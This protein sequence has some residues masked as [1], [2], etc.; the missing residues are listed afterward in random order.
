MLDNVNMNLKKYIY[1]TTG[2]YLNRSLNIHV[3]RIFFLY[4]MILEKH[5]ILLISVEK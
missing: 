5:I 1:C 4:R 2:L 3:V